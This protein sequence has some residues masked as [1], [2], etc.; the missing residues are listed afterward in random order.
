MQSNQRYHR[1]FR[2]ALMLLVIAG[3]ANSLYYGRQRHELRQELTRLA[4]Q[5]GYLNVEDDTRVHVVAIPE[6]A[7]IIPPG[8]DAAHIWRFRI[9]LPTGYSNS[10]M[11][12]SRV[13][14]ADSP[15]SRG[16][17]GRSSGSPNKEPTE[18]ELIISLLK[19]EKGWLLSRKSDGSS[20]ATTLSSELS[21]DTLDDWVVEPVVTP[22]SGPKSFAANEPIC[23]L[24][25]RGRDAVEPREAEP[26]FF[27]GFVFYMY[28]SNYQDIMDQWAQGKI[29]Q[30]PETPDE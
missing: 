16:G 27:P 19:T 20:G 15:R 5:V 9:Y 26:P 30:W 22:T 10:V 3:V 29:E 25:V 21:F 18:S 28:D 1:T 12:W 14:S 17:G 6:T 2:V 24:R 8:V 11:S 4:R 13:V 23:I 7:D